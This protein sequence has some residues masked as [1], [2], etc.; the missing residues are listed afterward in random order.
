MAIASYNW[1]SR[2]SYNWRWQVLTV[3]RE[4]KVAI[5]GCKSRSPVISGDRE[6]QLAIAS[7]NW[8]WQVLTGDR[9]L[10]VAIAGCNK[11]R[12]RVTPL[13]NNFW[14]SWEKNPRNS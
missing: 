4:L 3:D 12:S 2:V 13:R 11:S 5:A 7:Y 9:E 6:L 8:R 14:N 10:K 1:R